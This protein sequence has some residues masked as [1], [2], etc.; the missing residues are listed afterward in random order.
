MI[1]VVCLDDC[2]GMA[3]NRRRQSR[4]SLLIA[5]L[6]AEAK[7]A[8]IHMD[9]RSALLFEGCGAN[10]IDEDNFAENAGVGELCF[11]EFIS[12]A[13]LEARAEKLI[14]YRW[15]R[16]YQSDLKFDIDLGRWSLQ[17]SLDFPGSS[18]D[19]ITKEVYIR[20]Q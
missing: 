11:A 20:E 2:L 15:N 8:A 4:D 12:P 9:P 3:F 6:C 17:Q 14:I 18:H 10:I 1:L 5:D 7:G 16:R 13:L 19:N